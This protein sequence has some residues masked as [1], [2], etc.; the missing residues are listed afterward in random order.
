[1]IHRTC[2]YPWCQAQATTKQGYCDKHQRVVWRKEARY[3][4]GTSKFY[5]LKAWRDLRAA[6]LAVHPVCVGCGQEATVVDHIKPIRRGQQLDVLAALDWSN[7]QAMC[8]RCHN[9]KR[10]HERH[11]QRAET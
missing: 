2:R 11:E 7:L 6:F 8:D 5:S 1:M 10:G 9:Q 3:N 4:R